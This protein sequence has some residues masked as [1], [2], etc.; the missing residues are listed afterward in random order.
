M[1]RKEAFSA[2]SAICRGGSLAQERNRRHEAENG[3]FPLVI[4][5]E[6]NKDKPLTLL[7]LCDMVIKEVF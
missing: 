6:K 2:L 5:Y 7:K 3:S 4:L 1:F